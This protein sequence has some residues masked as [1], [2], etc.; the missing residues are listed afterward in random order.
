MNNKIKKGYPDNLIILQEFKNYPLNDP[1]DSQNKSI[2]FTGLEDS[3]DCREFLRV[4]Y[5]LNSLY[6]QELE[7]MCKSCKEQTEALL[8]E[9]DGL[10][11]KLERYE[12]KI[13]VFETA[14][15]DVV[16][17]FLICVL[18]A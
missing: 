7:F 16:R 12:E 2:S 5:N 6:K 3:S 11:E 17:L 14:T 9:I 10:K 13:L 8:N 18:N 15:S 4:Q 1:N